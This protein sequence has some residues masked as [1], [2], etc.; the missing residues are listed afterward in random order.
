MFPI[1]YSCYIER[2][3]GPTRARLRR[4]GQTPE[5]DVNLTGELAAEVKIR[6]LIRPG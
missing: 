4:G 6:W 5:L 2:N 1:I 3:Q